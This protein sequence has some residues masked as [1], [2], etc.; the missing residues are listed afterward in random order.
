[1]NPFDPYRHDP[2]AYRLL[3][4]TDPQRHPWLRAG[5]SPAQ[6]AA[7]Q[8][9]ENGRLRGVGDVVARATSAVG[10]KP[11]APCKQRQATLNRWFPFS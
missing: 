8:R 5:W 2:R 4:T 3:V 7:A 9:A 10:I 11:C 6:I 1:M